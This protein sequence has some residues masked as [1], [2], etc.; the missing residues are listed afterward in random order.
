MDFERDA[1]STLTESLDELGELWKWENETWLV[2]SNKL[3]TATAM[4]TTDSFPLNTKVPAVGATNIQVQ[5]RH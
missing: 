1:E 5:Y 3:G 4:K 2:D